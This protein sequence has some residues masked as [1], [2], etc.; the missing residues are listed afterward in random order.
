MKD[1]Q[2][3]FLFDCRKKKLAKNTFRSRKSQISRR[4]SSWDKRAKTRDLKFVVGGLRSLFVPPRA[5]LKRIENYSR[6][7][8]I[9]VR[10]I[11][12]LIL[13]AKHGCALSAMAKKLANL[14]HC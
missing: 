10:V 1:E 14:I 6:E 5:Q 8:A 12:A 13:V 7:V 3:L 9:N 4:L 2:E 11:V